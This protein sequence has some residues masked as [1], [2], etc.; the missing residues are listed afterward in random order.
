MYS[1]LYYIHTYLFMCPF[2]FLITAT[3]EIPD[4]QLP[5]IETLRVKITDGPA[6]KIGEHFDQVSDFIGLLLIILR[7]SEQWYC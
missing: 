5:G 4:C 6:S 2:F 3:T 1:Y 7:Y